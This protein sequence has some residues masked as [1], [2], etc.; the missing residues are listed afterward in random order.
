MTKIKVPEEDREQT[1]AAALNNIN[2]LIFAEGAPLGSERYF[3]VRR[4][5]V[6]TLKDCG[7][8]IENVAPVKLGTYAKNLLRDAVDMEGIEV[9]KSMWP[10]ADEL[11]KAGLGTMSRAHGPSNGWKRLTPTKEGKLYRG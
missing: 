6:D 7:Y 10:F 3:E 4:L 2:Q 11:V 1:L 8:S 9:P 5:C